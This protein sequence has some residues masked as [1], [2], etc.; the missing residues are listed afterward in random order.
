MWSWPWQEARGSAPPCLVLSLK[1]STLCKKG[2]FHIQA[3]RYGMFHE[4]LIQKQS[5]IYPKVNIHC[6]SRLHALALFWIC[7]ARAKKKQQGV[8]VA[9]RLW[10]WR[11]KCLTSG[12]SLEIS[13]FPDPNCF[14]C[15]K[16]N[17]G[18]QEINIH[19]MPSWW[20]CLQKIPRG[21][22]LSFFASCCE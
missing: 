22:F 2:V 7:T 3:R 17:R 5:R 12:R 19:L 6:W 4:I 8:W 11:Q 20:N 18:G 16:R 9:H 15:S 21:S 13:W 1:L 10:V 14:A